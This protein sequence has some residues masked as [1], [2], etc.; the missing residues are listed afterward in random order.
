MPR[1]LFL[2]ALTAGLSLAYN[3]YDGQITSIK[4][5]DRDQFQWIRINKDKFK[6]NATLLDLIGRKF[7]PKEA[8]VVEATAQ[9]T[10]MG[11][12]EQTVAKMEFKTIVDIERGRVKSDSA[13][14]LFA[15]GTR[16]DLQTTVIDYER[17][18][19]MVS[20]EAKKI[21]MKYNIKESTPISISID[22]IDVQLNT[23]L[24]M[25]Y[26]INEIMNQRRDRF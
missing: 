5:N 3:N 25:V 9:F 26:K 14:K 19:M 10:G 6:V 15:F 24:P 2:L 21:C 17:L 8:F 12:G 7:P 16:E 1:N 4:I 23:S 13:H 11:S 18:R 22:E 20:N